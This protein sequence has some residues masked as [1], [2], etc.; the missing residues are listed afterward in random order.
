M[1]MQLI[2]TKT[3][4]SAAAS[5]EFTSIPQTFTDL[6]LVANLKSGRNDGSMEDTCL[7]RLNGSSTSG[8]YNS[9]LLYGRGDITE[10]FSNTTSAGFTYFQINA[11]KSGNEGIFGSGQIYLPNYTSAVSKS[12][13]YE[14]VTEQNATI[15]FQVLG[16][17]LFTPTAA[18]T[19]ISFHPSSSPN[20]LMQYSSVSLYGIT[21]GS[22]GATVS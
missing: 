21:K 4:V 18:I 14:A 17:G 13:S 7:I 12:V 3:L 20:T 8:Q 16:A 15:S 9:R 2:E 19:S 10:S 11:N 6:L 1:T 22:G 5:I